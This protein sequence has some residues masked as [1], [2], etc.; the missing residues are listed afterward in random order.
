MTNT[1]DRFAPKNAHPATV[2]ANRRNTEH[3]DFNNKE[4]FEA[5][6]RGF[7][8]SVPDGVIPYNDQNQAWDMRL[9]DF[10]DNESA[11]ETVNP[12]LWRQAQ[13]NTNHGLY[14]VSDRVYQIRGLDLANMTI[15]E[16]D[17]GLILYDVLT[18]AEVAAASLDLYFQHRPHKP[19]KTVIYSH[20]HLDHYGGVKGVINQE[21][22]D[23]GT[24]NVI[25]PDGFMEAVGDEGILT[26]NA[27]GRRG[28]YQFG[29]FLKRGPQGQVDS[30]LGKVVAHGSFGLIAPTQLIVED[31]ETHTID[32]VEIVF[33]M[34]PDSEAPAEMHIY[35]PQFKV[36]NLAENAVHN[37]HNFI[38]L[39]GTVVRDPRLW[40]S[41]VDKAIVLF[42]DACDVLIGQHHWPI[43]GREDIVAFLEDYRDLFK[44]IHDQTLRMLNKGM[45]PAEIAEVLRHPPGLAKQW[46][47]R[48]YYGTISHNSKAVYQRYMSWYDANPAN[49][50]P[51]PPVETAQQTLRYMGGAQTI[52]SKATEDFEK[53]EFRWVAQIMS[54]VVYAEPQNMEA[55]A[56]AADAL[57]QLGYQAE[58][59]TW[60]NAY[61][62]GAQE[63]RTG[64]EKTGP[65]P[66]LGPDMMEAIGP[67]TLLD[68]LAIRLI[69]EKA[70]ERELRILWHV[71]DENLM[72]LL[73]LKN[74]TLSYREVANAPSVA[75][76]AHL[77]KPD[78][79]NLVLGTVSVEDLLAK[80]AIKI[81]GDVNA[82]TDLFA[83]LDEFEYMFDIVTPL[84]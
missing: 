51:L 3:L 69:P 73:T 19:V 34:A 82:I 11:P 4:D 33:Q 64:V 74:Q 59:A 14:Q 72:L 49:L 30:G 77:V 15:I 78:L 35:L 22:V 48:E 7:I 24:V 16:G 29:T 67:G 56:L 65:R 47:L 66:R 9:Y 54:Q 42:G 37:L 36:L 6:Q 28:Q 25:A 71:T 26:S 60:R 46:G 39:R 50:N 2:A 23:S 21:D 52:I 62:Y 68:Y 53:G 27:V 13:L 70:G 76:T 45:K 5:A 31:T 79:A 38:P 44:H 58:S 17:T 75:A 81:D 63:L 43:W 8:G 20:S 12:S 57:E 32:G 10:L 83:M 40:A 1:S 84:T 41:Y 18:T 80:E 55:R 61:L